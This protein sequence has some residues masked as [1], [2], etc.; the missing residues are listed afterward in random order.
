VLVRPWRLAAGVCFGLALGTKWNALYLL[1]AFALLSLAWDLGARRLAGAGRSAPVALLRDGIPAFV[2]LVVVAALVYVGTWASWLATSGGYGRDWGAKNPDAFTV[3]LLGDPLAS[4]L[5]YQLAIWNFHTGDYINNATHAY[6]ANPIGWLVVARPIGIDAVNDIK[7]GT[8]GCAG[9]ENCI[10]VISGL[11]TPTLWWGA[12]IALVAAAI[13]WVG[14]RDWR[15]GVP[16]VG[17]LSGWLPWFLYQD[18]PLFFFY[19]IVFLPFSVMAL[20]L[21][22]GLVLGPAGSPRRRMIG[23]VLVGVFVALVGANF[24]YLYPV[25]TD[26]VVPRSVWL[27]RMWFRTWI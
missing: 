9:P 15:M 25:L 21:C 14:A 22:L 20:A 1:A 23:G 7:P 16:V 11:G 4:L 26:E 2:S 8:N 24:A 6:R 17:V 19:A 3:R 5:H 10:S 27:A 12:V 18:R 13:L